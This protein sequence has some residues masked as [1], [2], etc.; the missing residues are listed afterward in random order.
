MVAQRTPEWYE[1]RKGLVTASNAG[2][3][4]GLDP[5]REPEDVLRAMVREAHGAEPEFTGNAATM[6]GTFHESGARAEYAM[7]TGRAPVSCGFFVHRGGWLGASPDSLVSDSSED[8]PEGL[9]EIKCPYRLREGRA[10]EHRPIA[11]QP[12]YYAQT[13]V[14][15]LCTNRLWCDFYQWAPSGTLLERVYRDD[16]WL[17]TYIPQLR[18]FYESYLEAVQAPDEHLEAKRKVIDNATARKLVAE[19]DEVCDALEF[20]QTRKAEILEALVGM[21]KDR[22]ALVCGRKLT[23]V[24]RQGSVSYAKVVK[25][26]CPTVD[27]EPYRGKPSVSWRLT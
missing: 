24:E 5:H 26:H 12:H 15:M 20:A 19:Y 16:A 7:E 13:Q 6:Y 14:Q 27:L 2:A 22:D 11:E 9:L 10:G 17:E 25:D 23:R 1:A 21:A 4:L 8:S 18:A 3:I